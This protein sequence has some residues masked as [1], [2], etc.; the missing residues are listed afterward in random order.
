MLRQR[1]ALKD[2]AGLGKIHCQLVH[3]GLRVLAVGALEVGKLDNLQILRSRATV[4]AIGALLRQGARLR[5]RM[6][7]KGNNVIADND[8]LAIGRA[9]N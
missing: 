9:K 3:I 4:R 2:D 7:A 8:V 5:V 1:I 6:L